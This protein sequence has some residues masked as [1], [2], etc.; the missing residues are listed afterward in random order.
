MRVQD[1]RHSFIKYQE[2]IKTLGLEW[3]DKSLL[4]SEYLN[5]SIPDL[6]N[7]IKEEQSEHV[8]SVLMMI[9]YLKVDAKS[10]TIVPK[11][12]LIYSRK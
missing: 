5:Y 1:I 9:L 12:H 10:K 8:K 2:S 11:L 3:I 6:Y 4:K 7:A